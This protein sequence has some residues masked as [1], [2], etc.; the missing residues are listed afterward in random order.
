M[1]IPVILSG[2][3][4]TRLWPLSR[5]Q[6]PKQLLRLCGDSSLL[7]QTV[8][9][10]EHWTDISTPV[11]VCNE[12][13]RFQVADQL[14]HTWAKNARIALEPVGRNTAP[15]VAVAAMLALR[16]H[17]DTD[18]V[19]LVL[20]SDHVIQDPA[21]FKAAVNTAVEAADHQALVTFGIVPHAA[22]T[23]Y[24]YIHRGESTLDH[25]R[26][27]FRVD[28][29]VE[30]PDRET[31][32]TYISSGE[33]YWN[34]GMFL[35]RSSTILDE[36]TNWAPAIVEHARQAVDAAVHDMDFCRL[37]SAPMESC[38]ADSIDY[39]VMEKTENAMVVPLEAGW[40]DVGSWAAL[41]DIGDK[42]A[43]GNVVTGDVWVE[44]AQNCYLH[45][46]NKMIAAVG[47]SDLVVVETLD[48]VMVT[49][50]E[51]AQDVKN[52]V[53][54]LRQADRDEALVHRKVHRPWGYY[55]S[56]DDGYRF[57]VKRIMVKPEASLSLQKH[58]HRAEHWV[59]VSGTAE[60]TC[61]SE[62]RTLSENQSTYIPLGVTHRLANPG[63]I[64]LEII[65]VQSGPYLD[66][67]DIV[68]LDDRYGR[69]N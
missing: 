3:S 49:H 42:N 29:F 52:L 55:D 37:A 50:R 57:K 8:Q 14:Q 21:A 24:G 62:T 68:R 22:E 15:A 64:P 12:H 10:L 20:P 51:R 54:Q 69:H 65:E 41:W 44:D 32:E 16:D 58:H 26:A 59:V 61:D 7:Q 40:S 17:P 39:A 18:P 66:E 56:I 36:L 30:K 45:A 31:A 25:D 5:D 27:C 67:D 2:G 11:V 4:G 63:K 19:L 46:E 9:R 28:R 33:Y 53:E 13:H 23:G 43:Q 38:P 60:V 48:G 35:F 47:V 34:S 1:L 6:R